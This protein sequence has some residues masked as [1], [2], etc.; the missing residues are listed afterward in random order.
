MRNINH[1]CEA[2]PKASVWTMEKA[3]NLFSNENSLA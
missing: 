3:Q 1:T 2:V